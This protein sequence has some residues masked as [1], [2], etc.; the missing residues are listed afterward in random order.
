MIIDRNIICICYN[1]CIL[2]EASI[3]LMKV[4]PKFL[5]VMKAAIIVK[6]N[7]DYYGNTNNNFYIC[8]S[9]YSMIVERKISKFISINY[10]NILFCQKYS[11]FFSNLT[12]IK[13]ALIAYIYLIR[14][15]IK[16]K[17]SRSSFSSS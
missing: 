12:L 16:L 3:L 17:P 15:I 5:S 1:L 6:N 2:F 13:K 7:F 4:Y 10:I 11:D 8:K 14:S 9:C